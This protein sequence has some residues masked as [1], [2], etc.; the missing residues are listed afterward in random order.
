MSTEFH[1]NQD[2]GFTSDPRWQLRE[3]ER[4]LSRAEWIS[5]AAL[6]ITGMQG[7]YLA[8]VVVQQIHDQ[9]RRIS[10]VETVQTSNASKIE[11]LL[12]TTSRI[13]ANVSSLTDQSR[14]RRD[15]GAN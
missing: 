8:G 6:I 14:A 12:I 5:V 7:A 2:E 3:M 4:G 9:D 11:Q 15:R 1:S 13:D 10:A